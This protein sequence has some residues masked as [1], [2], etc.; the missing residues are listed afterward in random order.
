MLSRNLMVFQNL[1]HLSYSRRAQCRLLLLLW[2]ISSNISQT[3][4]EWIKGKK[5]RQ[6]RG[7]KEKISDYNDY[8]FYKS[9]YNNIR[10][11]YKFCSF[12]DYVYS[13]NYNDINNH[14]NIDNYYV[15]RNPK[16]KGLKK[17]NW[18]RSIKS[19]LTLQLLA[20]NQNF[21]I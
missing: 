15:F 14:D 4:S 17:E 20:R 21:F 8:V 18:N 5:K 12:Y 1:N 10:C 19:I 9:V 11:H 3:V 7:E 6:K 16:T 13:N 2:W